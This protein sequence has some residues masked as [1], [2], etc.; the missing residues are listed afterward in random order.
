[1]CMPRHLHAHLLKDILAH[2]SISEIP[3]YFYKVKSQNGVLGNEDADALALQA[4]KT[5][6]MADTSINQAGNP[7]LHLYWLVTPIK[8]PGSKIEKIWALSNL[9]D[10]SKQKIARQ[11][12]AGDS[13][14]RDIQ[15][16][17][18]AKPPERVQS[19]IHC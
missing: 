11:T 2:T 6:D 15:L 4:A 5:P 13:K 7:L 10:K 18:L 9:Q 8:I 19:Q 14:N 12:L 17:Q 1:M 16:H 3:L